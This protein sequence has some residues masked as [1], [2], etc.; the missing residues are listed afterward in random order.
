MEKNEIIAACRQVLPT[1]LETLNDEKYQLRGV[2]NSEA[3]LIVAIAEHFGVK[4]IIESGRA[5]GHSTN[6]LAKYFQSNPEMKIAS[7][8][9]DNHSEDAKYSE[10][11]LQK[12]SNLTLI[13]GDSFEVIPQTISGECIIFIDGPKG[14]D[15]LELCSRLLLDSRVKAVLIHDLHKNVFP[16]DI[17]ELVYTSTFFTDDKDF[18]EEFKSLDSD[19]WSVMEGT[20]YSPYVRD[21]KSVLS[22]GHTLGAIFNSSS[23]FNQPAHDNYLERR[24][25]TKPT[26]KKILIEKLFS[27]IHKIR[28]AF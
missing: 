28:L 21:G 11:Y 2:L 16:R 4:S 13:Y 17:A 25:Y 7:I 3:L 18:V 19:C 14:E 1:F 6:L 9:L 5:R 8:D 24:E 15:A 27:I 20:N 12:F 10:K 26:L 23:P 22:Y